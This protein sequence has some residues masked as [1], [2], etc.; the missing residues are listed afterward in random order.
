[1]IDVALLGTGGMMPLPNRFLTSLMCRLNGK[2]LLIDCG[3]CTQV[4][5]KMLGWGFKNIDVICFTHYHADHISGLPGMLLTIGNS[6][7]TDPLTLIG[8]KG[9]KSVFTGLMVIAPELPY[10]VNCIE[11]PENENKTYNISGFEI[12]TIKTEHIIT[13]IAY[14]IE[15]KRTGKFNVEK[16]KKLDI[17]IKYWSLLQ[18][19]ESV[20]FNGKVYTSDMVLGQERKGIKISY[21]T[22][23]RPVKS[24]YEFVKDSDLFICEGMY[25]EDEKLDKAIENKHMLF[26]EAAEIAK[27]GNVKELWLTHFSPSLNEPENFISSA[28]NIFENSIVAYDRMSKS[29]LFEN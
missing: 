23:S 13:C 22:D 2:Y 25:G 21:C 12:N 28:K 1:M 4:T 29:I 17:P 11:I 20:E 16:A 27:N 26:S 7:R 3:E 6:G 19:N 5:L 10:E 14:S 15:V 18:K 24:L 8:P 9:L